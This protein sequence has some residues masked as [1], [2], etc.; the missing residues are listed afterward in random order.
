[1]HHEE[2]PE[3][4]PGDNVGISIRGISHKDLKRGMVI[5]GVNNPSTVAETFT[6]QIIVIYHPTALAAGYTPVIHAHTAQQA[7]TFTKIINKIDP[8]TGQVSQEN[9]DFIKQGDAALIELTPLKPLV[10]EKYSEIPQLGRFAV[11][12]MGQTVAAGIV[13]DVVPKKI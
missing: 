10:I 3:A 1:M 8:K 13:T 12:D 6:G 5:S 7:C 9:P 2:I 4:V 11:R